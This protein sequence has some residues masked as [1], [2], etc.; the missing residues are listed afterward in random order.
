[1]G[2]GAGVEA[3]AFLLLH[4]KCVQTGTTKMLN[5]NNNNNELQKRSHS[6]T[7][8]STK[9]MSTMDT[10]MM[11]SFMFFHHM[12]FL[13]FTVDFLNCWAC[14]C[15]SSVDKEREKKINQNER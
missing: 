10:I 8:T 3:G 11:F 9:M 5:Q 15:N 4:P 7:M 2:V 1:M 6:L 13:S 12:A 14:D